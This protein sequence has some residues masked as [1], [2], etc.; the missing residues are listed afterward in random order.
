MSYKFHV[1][2]L[3][4]YLLLLS[5]K[6]AKVDAKAKILKQAKE[7]EAAATTE[8]EVLEITKNTLN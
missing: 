3:H 8:I 4:L 6:Q 2:F 1:Y 7:E 5:L